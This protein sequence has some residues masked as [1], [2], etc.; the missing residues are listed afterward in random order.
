MGGRENNNAGDLLAGRSRP[1]RAPHRLRARRRESILSLI[2]APLLRGAARPCS[3]LTPGEFKG[4]FKVRISLLRNHSGASALEE[5][6]SRPTPLI[7]RLLGCGNPSC[8]G[9]SGRRPGPAGRGGAEHAQGRW[10]VPNGPG[11]RWGAGGPT[12]PDVPAK[13]ASLRFWLLGADLGDGCACTTVETESGEG[14]GQS[15]APG[16]QYCACVHCPAFL[17]HW[18]GL[19]WAALDR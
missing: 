2:S 15:P 17:Q 16:P 5:P 11:T 9:W 6:P 4:A 18:H 10:P 3:W 7:S 19:P 14:Q 13:P 12:A 1:G 8:C